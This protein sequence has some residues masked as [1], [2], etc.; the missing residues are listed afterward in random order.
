LKATKGENMT[1]EMTEILNSPET[2]IQFVVKKVNGQPRK[3]G[4]LVGRLDKKG[5]LGNGL[6]LGNGI[7][8]LGWSRANFG[9]GDV[10]DKREALNIAIGRAQARETVPVCHSFK[11]DMLRFRDRCERY[12][13]GASVSD[14]LVMSG[15]NKCNCPGCKPM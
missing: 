6:G 8:R 15:Y 11:K 7:V 3:V 9:K 12:F 5:L 14:V 10:F 1:A 13:K 4:V 2:L